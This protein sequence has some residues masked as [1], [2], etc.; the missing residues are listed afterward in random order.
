MDNR[1]RL[2]IV[3]MQMLEHN[4]TH[5]EKYEKWADFA[6]TNQLADAGAL[7]NEAK[8]FT[9]NISAILRKNLNHLTPAGTAGNTAKR[10]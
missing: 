8:K 4:E 2:K 5:V 7:L 3:I 9:K 1:E 6:K 10:T